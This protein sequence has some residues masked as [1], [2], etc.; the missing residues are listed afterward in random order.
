MIQKRMIPASL[1]C[2]L[3]VRGNLA[4]VSAIAVNGAQTPNDRAVYREVF[5]ARVLAYLRVVSDGAVFEISRT[6][7]RI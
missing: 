5:A 1:L 6:E 2:A 4:Y 7:K 3:R